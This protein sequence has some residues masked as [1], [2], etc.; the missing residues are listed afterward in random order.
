[1]SLKYETV[2]EPLH[3]SWSDGC[4]AE[5]STVAVRDSTL[6]KIDHW[7]NLT[8]GQISNW[9][10]FKLVK[11]DHWS[12]SQVVKSAQFRYLA[13]FTKW[14]NLRLVKF[15]QWSNLIANQITNWSN[16]KL[17][18]FNHC[19]DSEVAQSAQFRDLAIFTKWSNLRPIP[20]VEYVC[21]LNTF[22]MFVN[23][24]TLD[25]DITGG[26]CLST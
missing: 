26:V 21:Q 1:M 24:T 25:A 19:S 16:S 8:T 22:V 15:D 5:D 3:R 20:L 18:R 10:N 17:V 9:S 11:F 4:F 23:L 12:N 6:V 13:I 7:S 14:S 2:S